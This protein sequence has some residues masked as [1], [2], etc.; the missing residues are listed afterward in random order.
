MF[1]LARPV[2]FSAYVFHI[3]GVASSTYL[4]TVDSFTGIWDDEFTFAVVRPSADSF[5]PYKCCKTPSGYYIDYVSCYYKPTHDF[6][7]D[8]YDS[9]SHQVVVQCGT[10]YVIT[11]IAKKLNPYSSLYNVD[12]IQCCRVGCVTRRG[13]GRTQILGKM[14]F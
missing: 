8:Y 6:H 10:G 5:Q 1:P 14:R 7:Y 3:S 13:T 9:P 2:D 12:W 11:G 4:L